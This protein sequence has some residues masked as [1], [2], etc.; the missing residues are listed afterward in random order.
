MSVSDLVAI[1]EAL[2]VTLPELLV[3]PAALDWRR[4]RQTV[5][6]DADDGRMLRAVWLLRQVDY[7]ARRYRQALDLRD[8]ASTADEVERQTGELRDA[9][10]GLDALRMQAEDEFGQ[11]A[12]LVPADVYPALVA[13]I[14]EHSAR[15][16]VGGVPGDDGWADGVVTRKDGRSLP[17]RYHADS[18]R[19]VPR[20]D[21]GRAER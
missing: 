8:R 15:S 13:Y 10:R 7:E 3:D 11:A 16:L 20:K 12:N 18:D 6:I 21:D 5:G 2:G 4:L 14:D 19:I 17:I 1:A 9:L